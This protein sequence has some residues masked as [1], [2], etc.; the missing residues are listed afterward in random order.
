MTE[1][2]ILDRIQKLIDKAMATPY[3]AEQQAFLQKADA[4]MIQYSIDQIELQRRSQTDPNI[5]GQAIIVKVCHVQEPGGTSDLDY[6]IRYSL[7]DLFNMVASHFH[8]KT[9]WKDS[10]G[11]SVPNGSRAL[12]GYP[13]D[14]EFVE[15]LF[16]QL[17]MHM[18]GN[19]QPQA[20]PSRPW[21][22]NMANFKNVGMKWQ[23]IH[24]KIYH[25]PDYPWK[26]QPWERRIGVSFTSRYRKFMEELGQDRVMTS[27]PATWRS[28]FIAGY[29]TRIRSRLREI[30]SQT[31]SDN[32]LLPALFKDKDAEVQ[33]RYYE[34]FPDE[35]P[36]PAEC[37]CRR[38]EDMRKPLKR[39]GPGSRG[40]TSGFRYRNAGAMNAGGRVANTAD[41]S[42]RGGRVGS[43]NKGEL[44]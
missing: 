30:R 37:T 23:E 5:K 21:V 33:E 9:M 19:L 20:D 42:T 44:K 1:E 38:C 16:L 7:N 17:K 43:G 39:T 34:M 18:V 2:K 10:E 13:S 27:S 4:L 35:R 11:Q 36:H 40:G 31:V 25:L 12:L 28:D 8:C 14:I 24:Y 41:L 22:E 32:D 6:E 26:D 29:V 3:E 15:M